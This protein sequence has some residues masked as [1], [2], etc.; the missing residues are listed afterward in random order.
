[1]GNKNEIIRRALNHHGI[2]VTTNIPEHIIDQLRLNGYKIRKSRKWQ[3][4]KRSVL[5]EES[6][7]TEHRLS[8]EPLINSIPGFQETHKNGIERWVKAGGISVFEADKLC[9]KHNIHPL[10]VYGSEWYSDYWAL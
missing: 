2:V 8:L 3:K 7:S 4:G 1:M 6:L 5:K 9:A 10:S